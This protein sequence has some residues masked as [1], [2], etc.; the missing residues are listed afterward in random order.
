MLLLKS[1]SYLILTLMVFISLIMAPLIP[2]NYLNSTILVALLLMWYVV[3]Y[4][5]FMSKGKL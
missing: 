4:K 5:T 3:I 2:F 1:V